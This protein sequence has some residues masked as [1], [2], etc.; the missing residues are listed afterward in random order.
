MALRIMGH[1]T[2]PEIPPAE[3]ERSR[4][5][6]QNQGGVSLES[7][8][9]V[10][11][12]VGDRPVN[13]GGQAYSVTTPQ[14]D[15]PIAF[16]PP[17][18]GIENFEI[19][20]TEQ[21]QQDAS[22]IF[23]TI[24][25]IQLALLVSPVGLI[26]IGVFT[27]DDETSS[28][29]FPPS[30]NGGSIDATGFTLKNNYFCVISSQESLRMGLNCSTSLKN[31]ILSSCKMVIASGDY[32]TEACTKPLTSDTVRS[33]CLL[34]MSSGAAALVILLFTPFQF[35]Q[36]RCIRW[37]RYRIFRGIFIS[38]SMLIG[39]AGLGIG[40]YYF[41][42]EYDYKVHEEVA[43]YQ[44]V[45]KGSSSSDYDTFIMHP[46]LYSASCGNISGT[47]ANRIQI[48]NPNTIWKLIAIIVLLI[49]NI[50]ETF[51]L[52]CFRQAMSDASIW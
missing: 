26:L 48:P 44:E 15:G 45:V 32:H 51:V 31:Q 42:V 22:S 36:D 20:E 35:M 23:T 16:A 43:T 9:S 46:L 39:L 4:R 7:T 21:K 50:T 2:I 14:S 37:K 47:F 10:H 17:R 8:P 11:A 24:R 28:C 30:C 29:C 25:W 12:N 52:Q 27:F 1:L 40:L 5:Y 33:C 6:R 49:V 34:G 41:S 13:G 18:E 19:T 38:V 3:K